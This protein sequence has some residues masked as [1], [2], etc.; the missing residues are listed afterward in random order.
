MDT[1]INL[2]LSNADPD[3]P[4]VIWNLSN[5]VSDMLLGVMVLLPVR[6]FADIFHGLRHIDS[7]RGVRSLSLHSSRMTKFN[8]DNFSLKV[9]SDPVI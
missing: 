8:K 9:N 4:P 7:D 3:T 6:L 5:S 2:R 1:G